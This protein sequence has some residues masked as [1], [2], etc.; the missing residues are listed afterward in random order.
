M[1]KSLLHC[2]ALHHVHSCVKLPAIHPCCALD[3]CAAL[4]CSCG[5]R[6]Q[7]SSWRLCT[8]SC[9]CCAGAAR[10]WKGISRGLARK[11]VPARLVVLKVSCRAMFNH[12][13]E[14]QSD[15]GTQH[16]AGLRK[17]MLGTVG[18]HDAKAAAW[19]WSSVNSWRAS[20]PARQLEHC[21]HC[22]MLE[23]ELLRVQQC[24]QHQQGGMPEEICVCN[25]LQIH[26]PL[27][28]QA[29]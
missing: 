14:V 18:W 6:L 17:C 4:P 20:K 9:C 27:A 2:S 29:Q 8:Q 5:G 19:G 7:R 24:V 22:V 11:I 1:C 23:G 16:P 13:E 21:G 26:R 28:H 15:G 10:S 3:G 25:C 12:R